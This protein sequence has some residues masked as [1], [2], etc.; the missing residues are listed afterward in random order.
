MV[1][2]Y[3]MIDLSPIVTGGKKVPTPV[4]KLMLIPDVSSSRDHR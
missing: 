1:N 2:A 3:G 4:P